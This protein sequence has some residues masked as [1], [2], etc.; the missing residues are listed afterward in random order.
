MI[1]TKL[2]NRYEILRE[3]GRGGMGVVYLARDPLLEREVAIKL[4]TPKLLSSEAEERFK[5]EARVIAKMDHPSIVGVHDIGEHEGA[6]FFVMPYVPGTSLRHFI[7]DG[8]L[9]LGQVVELGIQVSDALEYSHSSG[10]V[11][12]D[13]KPENIM[14][15]R[16]PSA[17]EIRARVTDFG[18]AMASTESRLTKTGTVVG[19]V[20][21]LSP[22]QVSANNIDSRSDLYSLGTVL[23]ECLAGTT[24]F[25]GEIQKVLYRIAH[26]YPPPLRSIGLDIHEELE[27]VIMQCMEKD[28]AKRPQHAREVSESLKNTG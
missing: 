26:E 10:V 23:Y 24:P 11:H 19:T 8:S 3:L 25:S 4:L 9:N 20:A 14:V 28:P 18:L 2:S 15:A 22:E 6:L 13:I 17:D 16:G 7:R 12:R 27:G 5:R 1:G 21:Y